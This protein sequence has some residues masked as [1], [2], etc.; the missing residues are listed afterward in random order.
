[1][2]H[3]HTVPSL[4]SIPTVVTTL[5]LKVKSFQFIIFLFVSFSTFAGLTL[6]DDVYMKI[7]MAAGAECC[8]V[9]NKKFT[10]NVQG[11]NTIVLQ[12]PA[13]EGNY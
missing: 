6:S 12:F 13:A 8:K 9:G 7:T 2:S 10:I 3:I 4:L 5:V 1:M 11:D